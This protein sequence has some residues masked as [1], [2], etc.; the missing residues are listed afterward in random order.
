MVD[1]LGAPSRP[2]LE[3]DP[4]RENRCSEMIM[5]VDENWSAIT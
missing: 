1:G 3:H 4:E 2:L 5:L